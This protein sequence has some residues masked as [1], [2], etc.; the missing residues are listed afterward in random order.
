MVQC[1]WLRRPTL[2]GYGNA[3]LYVWLPLVLHSWMLRKLNPF[4][5]YTW[6]IH[7]QH[8]QRETL[9][10]SMEHY[11]LET[12]NFLQ[13]HM[14]SC[15]TSAKQE[16]NMPLSLFESKTLITDITNITSC[17]LEDLAWLPW[18]PLKCCVC[19]VLRLW[20]WWKFLLLWLSH[21]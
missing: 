12:C 20:L 1:S 6:W 18:V 21:N 15:H 5:L 17:S 13:S 14:L 2:N 9:I 10:D 16:K 8:S 4:W 3:D 11:T 7:M 19:P